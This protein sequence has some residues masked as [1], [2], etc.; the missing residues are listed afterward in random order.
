LEEIVIR[1]QPKQEE[2]LSCPADIVIFGG[3]AGSGKSWSLLL[4]PL[5]YANVKGFNAVIF[6]RETPQIRKTGGLWQKAKNLYIPIGGKPNKSSL[7][8][9]I[10][11]AIIQFSHMEHEDDKY[12]W[13]GVEICFIGFDELTQF[14]E[15]QFWYLLRSNRSDCGVSPYIRATCNPDPD[16]FVYPLIKWW[17]DD[18]DEYPDYSKSGIIR[19]F[20]RYNDKIYWADTA[21]ELKKDFPDELPKSFTFIPAKLE[22]NQ[23]FLEKDPAY[24]SNLNALSKVD[25]ER[26]KKGNWKIRPTAGN[27][28]NRSWF[29]IIDILPSNIIAKVRFWDR[30][31][32]KKKK[33]KYTAGLKLLK[34]SDN[35]FYIEHVDRFKEGPLETKKRIKNVATQDSKETPIR[36]E[37]EPGASGVFEIDD[38]IRYLAGFDVKSKCPSGDK[39]TRAKPASAS[40][41][42]G[43]IKILKGP[44]NEDFLIEAHNFD[45][46][47]EYKDQIDSLSGAFDELTDT[48]PIVKESYISSVDYGGEKRSII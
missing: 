18:N 29:E 39:V 6:R 31:A 44:W 23:I 10:N 22:D 36:L 3:A 33:S 7:E 9:V 41:E 14:E 28:F 11:E 48:T 47:A 16:S 34:S 46:D 26:L 38:M 24:K 45:A 20:V 37:Q 5:R 1:P 27:I 15:D 19:Y 43:N 13:D 4:D 32:T 35:V 25:R 2:F 21:D 30:A 17:L 8:F 42:A 40:A 12:N